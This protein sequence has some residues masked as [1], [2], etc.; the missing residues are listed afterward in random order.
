MIGLPNKYLI[1]N[2]AIVLVMGLLTGLPLR[3]AIIGAK[4]DPIRAW[5]VAHSVFVMDGLMMLII[6]LIIPHLILDELATWVLVGSLVASGYGFVLAFTVGA[7]KGLR[8]LTAKPF[9]LNTLLFAAHVIGASGSLIGSVIVI[10][11]SLK[12]IS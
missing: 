6:G 2:G 11:G 9:G 12:A 4:P 3:Q 5:R 1:L 10:Y 7:F 8:G